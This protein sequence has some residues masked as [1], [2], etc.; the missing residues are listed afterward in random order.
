MTRWLGGLR[1][2]LGRFSRNEKG[3][4]IVLF[5]LATYLPD[6]RQALDNL[7]KR[8]DLAAIRGVVNTL[9]QTEK[10]GTP[11]AQSLRVLAGEFR[12]E[13]MMKAEEK[14]AKLPATLTV[15]L[16]LFIMP[17]LFVV[18]IGP[19]VLSTLDNLINLKL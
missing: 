18:L 6:R 11:L 12:N 1:N 17:S 7:N 16:I 19:A 14:A 5:A 2:K 8:T 4:A 3:A 9:T 10:Y 15:P 13:R